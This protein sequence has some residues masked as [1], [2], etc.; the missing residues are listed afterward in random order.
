[1]TVL[2]TPSPDPKN[3]KEQGTLTAAVSVLSAGET[4]RILPGNWPG[5]VT[6]PP[7]VSLQGSGRDNT[8][9]PGK[10]IMPG[11]GDI[12]NLD[13]PASS[14]LI[15]G[16]GS[17]DFRNLYMDGDATFQSGRLTGDN[18]FSR[19]GQGTVTVIVGGGAT[20]NISNSTLGPVAVAGTSSILLS[21]VFALGQGGGTAL[22]KQVTVGTTIDV[23]GGVMTAQ[24][25]TV[26]QSAT[27]GS[28]GGMVIPP[29]GRV[30]ILGK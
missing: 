28:A 19:S 1:M 15:Y 7:Q 29:G 6:F 22:I 30:S 8:I 26:Q 14:E 23:Q 20:I 11:G 3:T 10:L 16:G 21:S 25:V 4:L 2:L 27:I 13:L 17:G 5:D 24:Q 18:V 12:R 9:L